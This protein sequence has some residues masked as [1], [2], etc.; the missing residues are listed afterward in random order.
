MNKKLNNL[1]DFFGFLHTVSSRTRRNKLDSFTFYSHTLTLGRQPFWMSTA[2]PA[3]NNKTLIKS[4]AAPIYLELFVISIGL[5]IEAPFIP[6]PDGSSCRALCLPLGLSET[7]IATFI[8]QIRIF[9]HI[10]G[11]Q[12]ENGLLRHPT[13]PHPSAE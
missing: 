7:P 13:A 6:A 5:L 12:K 3:K 2:V 9:I 4:N 11:T 1:L 8:Q 10:Y